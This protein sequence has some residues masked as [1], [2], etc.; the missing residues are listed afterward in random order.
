MIAGHRSSVAYAALGIPPGGFRVWHPLLLYCFFCFVFF[1]FLSYN[2]TKSLVKNNYQSLWEN[3]KVRIHCNS[4]LEGFREKG[5]NL[6]SNSASRLSAVGVRLLTHTLLG[7][8]FFSQT[9]HLEPLLFPS[10]HL[11]GVERVQMKAPSRSAQLEAGR[12]LDGVQKLAP[13]RLLVTELWEL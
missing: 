9:N 13:H 2:A 4:V 12:R 11:S 6:Y 1:V 7:T 10:S 8:R 3:T 5:L